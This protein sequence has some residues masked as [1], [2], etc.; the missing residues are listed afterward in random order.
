MN[1]LKAES[2][3]YIN[4]PERPDRRQRLENQLCNFG[5]RVQKIN[6]IRFNDAFTSLGYKI[7][8]RL[9]GQRGYIGIYLAHL[10][11]LR[12]IRKNL[13][14]DAE[15][16][17]LLEDDVIIGSDFSWDDL[18]N[19]V[20]IPK[21]WEIILLA[22]RYRLNKGYEGQGNIE[23]ERLLDNEKYKTGAPVLLKKP[24]ENMYARVLISLFLRT[25]R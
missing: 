17:V 6:G 10:N 22:P 18:T 24:G 9:I 25:C 5:G 1:K 11:A 20:L 15:N 3:L 8:D 23:T 12:W 4:L 19:D 7:P 2:V 16:I 14:E 13:S 21:D